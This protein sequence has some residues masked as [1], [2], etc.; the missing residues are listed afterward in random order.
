MPTEEEASAGAPSESPKRS[1]FISLI[2]LSSCCFFSRSLRCSGVSPSNRA[3][4]SLFANISSSCLSL[5]S[6]SANWE[7]EGVAMAGPALSSCR[8][9]SSSSSA[10]ATT[11]LPPKVGTLKFSQSP[12]S[13]DII[14]IRVHV[15]KNYV[16]YPL[17]FISFFLGRVAH[18]SSGHPGKNNRFDENKLFIFYKKQFITTILIKTNFWG[19]SMA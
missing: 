15:S 4:L 10:A 5:R 13:S 6:F 1:S 18:V 9:R 16:I 3:N 7:A 2:S 8:V 19:E 11:A 17:L 12:S 14:V